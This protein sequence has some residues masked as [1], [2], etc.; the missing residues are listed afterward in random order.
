MPILDN[1]HGFAA[2]QTVGWPLGYTAPQ[3]FTLEFAQAYGSYERLVNVEVTAIAHQPGE[4]FGPACS[5]G[6]TAVGQL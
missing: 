2:G 4:A 5:F 6:L 1:F 3:R